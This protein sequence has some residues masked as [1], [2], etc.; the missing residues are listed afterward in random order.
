[1]E[2]GEAGCESGSP[3]DTKTKDRLFPKNDRQP[4]RGFRQ[5]NS[6]ICWW[7]L[8]PVWIPLSLA[9]HCEHYSSPLNMGGEEKRDVRPA[10]EELTSDVR[11][12]YRHRLLK[13][14]GSPSK[15]S[16]DSMLP[17][18]ETVPCSSKAGPARS[19]LSSIVWS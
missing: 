2:A 17:T 10:S 13:W 11:S 15:S 4:L 3:Q 9:R 6:K 7:R 1:M 19:L 12:I 16:T 18:G 5:G 14:Q 8:N